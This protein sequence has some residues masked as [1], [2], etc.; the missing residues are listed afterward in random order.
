MKT[1]NV[2]MMVGVLMT[3]AVIVGCVNTET[4]P[5]VTDV[6]GDA[7]PTGDT[8]NELKVAAT[9]VGDYL[10]TYCVTNGGAMITGPK[11]TVTWRNLPVGSRFVRAVLPAPTDVLAIPAF[12]NGY[13]VTSIGELAFSNCAKVKSVTIPEGVTSI[14]AFAFPMCDQL[15]S[16]TIP[17][18]VTNIGLHAFGSCRKLESVTIPSPTIN[19]GYLAFGFCK[20]LKS[21]TILSDVMSIES[22][23]F[24]GCTDLKS[25]V[26]PKGA[27]VEKG[28]F[29]EGCKVQRK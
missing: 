17:S 20:T 10:Y 27:T 23:A 6:F 9:L 4:R 16:V 14:E 8:T 5:F 29:P 18:T 3:V 15:K 25:V 2:L 1:R 24:K 12:L 7:A 19:I 26:I 22:S 28:A 13:P 21:V 11:Q